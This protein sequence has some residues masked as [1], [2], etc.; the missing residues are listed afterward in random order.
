MG[1]KS[2]GCIR[3]KDPS[4]LLMAWCRKLKCVN[5]CIMYARFP[6]YTT[7]KLPPCRYR[8]HPPQNVIPSNKYHTGCIQGR[9]CRVCTPDRYYSIQTDN[10]GKDDAMAMTTQNTGRNPVQ[11]T[12]RFLA[13][14]PFFVDAEG[15]PV[16]VDIAFLIIQ[17]STLPQTRTIS[18]V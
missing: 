2:Q 18:M 15:L 4:I 10:S 12:D 11:L 1:L 9:V 8:I 14:P 5:Q 7:P 3:D 16:L 6:A 13:P 17:L